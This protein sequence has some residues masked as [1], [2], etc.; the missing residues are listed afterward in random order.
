MPSLT[1]YRA[2]AGS[3]KTFRLAAEYLKRVLIEPEYYHRLLAVTFT[4]K[5]TAEMK[6]RIM[7]ELFSISQGQQ[8]HMAN[9]LQKEINLPFDLMQQ[10]AR[11][12][13]ALI[14]HDYSRFAVSTIDSFMQRVV[15][16]LLW[17]VGEQGGVDIQL[18]P[19]PILEHA[20]DNLLDFAPQVDELMK[21]LTSMG[22]NL[23]DEGKG[24]VSY[25]HLTLPTKR[26]V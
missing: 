7:R 11:K 4:N 6:D 2:S 25:T 5:A 23:M 22:Q 18:D 14:L 8:N 17:E 3:G 21:W 20:A 12:A 10:Q 19:Q 26:I 24:S 13:L 15:Q 1:I 16:A 9:T